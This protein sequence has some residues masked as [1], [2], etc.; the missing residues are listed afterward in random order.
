MVLPVLERLGP[1]FQPLAVPEYSVQTGD[2]MTKFSHIEIN[3]SN[4]AKS[5]RF[6][7]MVLIPLGWRRLNCLK[8]CTSFTD[9]H[10]KII[11]S[12]TEPGYA[13]MGYHR[14]RVGLNHIAISVGTKEELDHFYTATLQKNQVPC[15]YEGEPNGNSEYYTVLFEDPD[16]IKLEVVFAPDYCESG[17]WTNNFQD[18]F[19]P[20]ENSL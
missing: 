4:Y 15:L 16:R 11:L 20:Y 9:G 6:Y 5:I 8:E 12:P 13:D 1:A 14:K 2:L 17:H 19:D 10:M 3:V 7:D 18:T